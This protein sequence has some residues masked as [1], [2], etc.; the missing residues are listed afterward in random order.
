MCMNFPASSCK[1]GK[2]ARFC[3]YNWFC[4]KRTKYSPGLSQSGESY[5]G[6]NEYKKPYQKFVYMHFVVFLWVWQNCQGGGAKSPLEMTLLLR[7]VTYFSINFLYC[8]YWPDCVIVK[9]AFLHFFYS[10]TSSSPGHLYFV[11]KPLYLSY[12]I[13]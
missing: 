8:L 1:K 5:C 4:H 12:L 3:K 6:A 10:Q 13:R 2:K 11:V 9:I 7:L